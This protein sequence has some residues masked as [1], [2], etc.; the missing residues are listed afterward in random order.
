M[1]DEDTDELDD[2]FILQEH[3]CLIRERD[4]HQEH[5]IAKPFEQFSPC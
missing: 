1:D 2:V 3:V 4:W 5:R